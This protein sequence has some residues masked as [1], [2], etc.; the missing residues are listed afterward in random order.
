M[1]KEKYENYRQKYN[2][3]ISEKNARIIQLEQEKRQRE[4][5]FEKLFDIKISLE[6]ELIVYCQLLDSLEINLN[7]L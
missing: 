5:D 1:L 2:N 7:S 6:R 4:E 3:E